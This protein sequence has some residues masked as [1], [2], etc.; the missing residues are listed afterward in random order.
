MD[1]ITLFLILVFIGVA[2]SLLFAKPKLATLVLIFFCTFDFG[3]FSRWFGLSRYF[4]RIPFFLSILLGFKIILDFSLRKIAITQKTRAIKILLNFFM[5]LFTITSVSMLY[6]DG[7]IT[8]SLYELRYYL[9][10]VVLCLGIYFYK[11]LPV[12]E[13]SFIKFIV[14]LGLVQIPFAVVQHASVSLMGMRLSQ[15]GLDIVSGTFATYLSL[16]FFQC[17]AMGLTLTYQLKVKRPILKVNNYILIVLFAIP[18]VLSFARAAMVFVVVSLTLA[19]LWQFYSQKS[20]I[21]V[22]RTIVPIALLFIV[23]VALFYQFFWQQHYKIRE[24]LDI[25]FAIEYSFRE[26][27]SYMFY[28]AGGYALMGRARALTESISLISQSLPRFLLGLGPGSASEAN[29]LGEKGKYFYEYGPFAGLGRTQASKTITE[30]GFLGVM[31]FIALFSLLLKEVKKAKALFK[32]N[33][34]MDIYFIILV[35]II[36][37]SFYARILNAAIALFILAYFIAI[38]QNAVDTKVKKP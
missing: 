22:W 35:N 5:L 24:Q 9:L 37:L 12:D 1:W 32:F 15:T 17:V 28:K 27:Q 8:L 3:F 36:M 30:Y 10:L 25:D 6:N 23:V 34:G 21:Y 18:L 19:F 11:P 4:P 7:S 33:L 20:F 13:H 2:I 14:I 26:P 16:V 31:T 29:L 38:T